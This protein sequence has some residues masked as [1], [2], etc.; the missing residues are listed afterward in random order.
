MTFKVVVKP[1]DG[2]DIT[3]EFLA[4]ADVGIGRLPREKSEPKVEEALRDV[5]RYLGGRLACLAR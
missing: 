2:D 4:T 1:A 5:A 3:V